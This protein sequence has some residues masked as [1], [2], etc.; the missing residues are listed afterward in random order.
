MSTDYNSHKLG[1][2]VSLLYIDTNRSSS[3][4]LATATAAEFNWFPGFVFVTRSPFFVPQIPVYQVILCHLRLRNGYSSPSSWEAQHR[5]KA[6]HSTPGHGQNSLKHSKG[7]SL[8]PSFFASL[9][10][11][12]PAAYPGPTDIVNMS[13][14]WHSLQWT[15]KNADYREMFTK[16]FIHHQWQFLPFQFRCSC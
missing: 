15:K 3:W 13:R 5:M 4:F 14:E 16:E 7:V 8:F 12:C 1:L 2:D 10:L 6:Q 11:S 9:K